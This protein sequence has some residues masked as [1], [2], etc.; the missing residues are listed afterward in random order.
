MPAAAR[1]PGR[2][3]PPA[4][5]RV[6]AGQPA[7]LQKPR[8]VIEKRPLGEEEQREATRGQPEDWR[9]VDAAKLLKLVQAL[10]WCAGA[11]GPSRVVP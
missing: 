9:A 6:A 11:R 3:M 8:G 4:R 10:G 2:R 5:G 7:E 1:C